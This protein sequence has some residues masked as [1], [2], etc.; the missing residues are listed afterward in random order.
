M[1]AHGR[2]GC[3]EDDPFVRRRCSPPDPR[4]RRT[5]GST[6]ATIS[7]A[8]MEEPSHS[9]TSCRSSRTSPTIQP[10]ST[11]PTASEGNPLAR[12]A[13]GDRR[14]DRG[15]AVNDFGQEQVSVPIGA[16]RR[17]LEQLGREPLAY[18]AGRQGHAADCRRR[19]DEI[20]AVEHGADAAALYSRR[21]SSDRGAGR[22]SLEA[23][24]DRAG[25]V[26]DCCPVPHITRRPAVEGTRRQRGDHPVRE[27]QP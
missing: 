12:A 8:A 3:G 7:P 6:P 24:A 19:D 15:A 1:A 26:T 13:P 11:L 17:S 16:E 10:L 14:S 22:V 4:P 2:S 20:D 9:E 27:T 5:L 21:L 18:E 25:P 23:R